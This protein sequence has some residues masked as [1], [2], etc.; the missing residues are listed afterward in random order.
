MV[1]SVFV[2]VCRVS[3]ASGWRIFM[4]GGDES[5]RHERLG[6]MQTLYEAQADYRRHGDK[7]AVIVKEE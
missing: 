6:T 2:C 4:L 1:E 7:I 3:V 5:H